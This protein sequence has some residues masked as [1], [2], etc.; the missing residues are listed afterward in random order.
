MGLV[1]LPM[2]DLL[3]DIV[4]LGLAVARKEIEDDRPEWLKAL[5]GAMHPEEPYY[6]FLY[7][8]QRKHGFFRSLEIGTRGGTSALH[9]AAGCPSGH[10]AT[11]DIDAGC[12]PNVE[13]IAHEHGLPNLKAYTGDSMYWRPEEGPEFDLLFIDG[14][15]T[16]G[17]LADYRHFREYLRPAT[18]GII[19]FDDTRLN[20]EMIEAWNSIQDRKIEVPELHYMGFGIA[21]K[22]GS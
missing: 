19:L 12:K 5:P 17:A 3:Q 2:N 11:L 1:G 13:A 20:D 16:I 14:V 6:H 15:H 18:G 9:L 4:D 22:E 7:Q 10:V 21:I 8:L